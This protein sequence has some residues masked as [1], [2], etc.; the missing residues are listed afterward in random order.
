MPIRA[1]GPRPVSELSRLLMQRGHEVTHE[2]ASADI[3][4]PRASDPQIVGGFKDILYALLCQD[5]FRKVVRDWAYGTSVSSGAN[6][7]YLGAYRQ[8]CTSHAGKNVLPYRSPTHWPAGSG[9]Y[10]RD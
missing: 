3:L 1:Q 5:S 8:L 7:Q 9:P 4:V 10:R 2:C 6:A